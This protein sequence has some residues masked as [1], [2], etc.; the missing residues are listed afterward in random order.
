MRILLKKRAGE[1]RYQ[2]I[3]TT[4]D[5]GLMISGNSLEGLFENAAAGLYSLITK[6][7]RVRERFSREVS[8]EADDLEGLLFGWLNKLIYLYETEG[9]LG[10]NFRVRI[11]DPLRLEAVITGEEM[12]RDRHRIKRLLKA[13]TYHQLEIKKGNGQWQA[14]VIL[15]V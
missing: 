1:K 2:V 7:D 11:T 6:P 10:K 4:A 13:V 3:G 14:R 5:I 9:L 12:D 8:V 15:D